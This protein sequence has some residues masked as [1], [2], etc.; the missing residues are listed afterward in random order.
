MLFMTDDR[1]G[2]HRPVRANIVA[3]VTSFIFMLCMTLLWWGMRGVMDLG[4]FVASGGPYAIR[5]QAPGWVWIVPVGILVGLVSVGVSMMGSR[6]S[7]C[8]RMYVLAWPLLFLSLGWNFLEYA[9]SGSRIA[10][11][12][13]V[14]GIV[15][16]LMGALPVHVYWR[17]RRRRGMFSEAAG[18][19]LQ[20][21]ERRRLSPAAV[22]LQLA[23]MA[24]AVLLGTCYFRFLS[25]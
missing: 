1:D 12:W 19:P 7:G 3:I 18:G 11:G 21:R 24:G 6:N 10:V 20:D 23:A 17:S 9:F 8:Y 5:H 16:V 15:F 14:C 4:G 2:I 25:G 22:T 13:L